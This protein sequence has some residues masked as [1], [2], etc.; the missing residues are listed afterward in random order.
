VTCRWVWAYCAPEREF[1]RAFA[2][3][4]WRT[5]G[6]GRLALVWAEP[7]V[8]DPDAHA[9]EST[10]FESNVV[11]GP[12]ADDCAIWVG[13]IGPDGY[14]LNCLHAKASRSVQDAEPRWTVGALGP[15]RINR[16]VSSLISSADHFSQLTSPPLPDFYHCCGSGDLVGL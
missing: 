15:P 6:W 13:A 7:L 2:K 11:R 8:V 10:R 14:G 3:G 12:G 5:G 1:A 9:D 4:L 16:S